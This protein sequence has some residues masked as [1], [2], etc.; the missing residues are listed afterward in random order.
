[1]AAVGKKNR[2]EKNQSSGIMVRVW[3]KTVVRWSKMGIYEV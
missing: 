3:I 1:M 2:S